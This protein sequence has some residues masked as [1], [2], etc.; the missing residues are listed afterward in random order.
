LSSQKASSANNSND[1]SN[2]NV[3]HLNLFSAPNSPCSPPSPVNEPHIKSPLAQTSNS[4]IAE[5]TKSLEEEKT[6]PF[7]TV[8]R[9]FKDQLLSF[10]TDLL[11]N[12]GDLIKNLSD[13]SKCVIFRQEQ[14]RQLIAI[15]YLSKEGREGYDDRIIIETEPVITSTCLCSF[16]NPF[17]LKTKSVIIDRSVNLLLTPFR[18]NM[19][20]VFKISFEYC[21]R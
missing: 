20:H 19:E 17:A 21:I 9:E 8:E 11:L 1:N 2:K 14:L 5:Q 18:I 10:T 7:E 15:L 3:I 16:K 6:P 12:S 4:P 13:F